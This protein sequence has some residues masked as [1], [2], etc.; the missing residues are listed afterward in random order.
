MWR[1]NTKILASCWASFAP[2]VKH[3]N[4]IL[5]GQNCQTTKLL[6]YRQTGPQQKN[7]PVADVI[8]LSVQGMQLIVDFIQLRAFLIPILF[9]LLLLTLFWAL[10]R[11]GS[12]GSGSTGSSASVTPLGLPLAVYLPPSDAQTKKRPQKVV[13]LRLGGQKC[14]QNPPSLSPPPPISHLPIYKTSWFC[15]N[16]ISSFPALEPF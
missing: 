14:W 6:N 4:A 13:L 3:P 7:M 12:S 5:F 1:K 11:R 10:L 15:W 2:R 8:F 9:L 16:G